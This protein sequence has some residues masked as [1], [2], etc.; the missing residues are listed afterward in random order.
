MRSG[1]TIE[2]TI[3][4]ALLCL[5]LALLGIFLANGVLKTKELGRTV[6][7]KGLSEQEVAADIAI[8]PISFSEAE[9]DLSNLY[10]AVE[11][12]TG[13][14]VAFLKNHG[15]TEDEITISAPSI[16][17]RLASRYDSAQT[18]RFRYTAKSTVSIYSVKVDLV[19]STMD[20]LVD[21][22]KQG[23]AIGGE[24]YETKTQFL[25]TQLNEIKP[26]MIEEATRN[27]RDVAERFAKDS[28]SKLGKIHRAQQGQFSIENRDQNTP[29]IK[30]VRIVSTIEY[31]LT[32]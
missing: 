27:A 10:S 2:A 19:R 17:D 32:D 23:I 5:G 6:T 28:N 1:R 22:G 11:S 14:I 25:F 12:K 31:Y 21:L 26:R 7:V 8:W 24:D 30:K 20:K 3:L 16:I 29:H 18:T 4:G 13:I 15:F 9:N